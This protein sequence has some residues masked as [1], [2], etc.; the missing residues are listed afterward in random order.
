MRLRLLRKCAE[1]RS[2]RRGAAFV[3]SGVNA[4]KD[5]HPTEHF[6]TAPRNA[7]P[8]EVS[9]ETRQQLLS[10]A[11]PILAVLVE[12]DYICTNEPV[13]QREMPIDRAGSAGLCASM[14]LGN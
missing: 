13:A 4:V 7:S 12:L 9:S 14:N 10:I 1:F 8:L 5:A 6:R 11:G 3:Q 2:E